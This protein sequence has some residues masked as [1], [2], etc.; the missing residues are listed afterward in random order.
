MM[1]RMHLEM[2]DRCN[3]NAV[4]QGPTSAQGRGLGSNLAWLDACRDSQ[5]AHRGAE[6]SRSGLRRQAEK[7]G[8][9]KNRHIQDSSGCCVRIAKL[10][11]MACVIDADIS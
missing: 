1:L 11:V 4:A 2:W 8:T 5:S 10:F 9:N 7:A 3:T 6:T